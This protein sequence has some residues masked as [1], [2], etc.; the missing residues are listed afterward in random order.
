[1]GTGTLSQGKTGEWGH[2]SVLGLALMS[3]E[4]PRPMGQLEG[5]KTKSER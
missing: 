1:M 5:G 2:T 3:W 4:C